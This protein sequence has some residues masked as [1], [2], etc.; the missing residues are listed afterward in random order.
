[1]PCSTVKPD[2]S[3]IGPQSFRWKGF[4]TIGM[5]LFQEIWSGNSFGPG[6]F[7]SL[8]GGAASP[9]CGAREDLHPEFHSSSSTRQNWTT[10][11]GIRKGHLAPKP[12]L[13]LLPG[14]GPSEKS[15]SGT[16]SVPNSHRTDQSQIQSLLNWIEIF[17]GTSVGFNWWGILRC[18]LWTFIL[19]NFSGT[20]PLGPYHGCSDVGAVS[21][22]W[23]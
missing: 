8:L 14:E 12:W 3:L 10:W 15:T 22:P 4:E 2:V 19:Q 7:W 11:A 20:S 16:V 5:K 21:N 6:E 9:E 1:M 23:R 13:W 18:L 17:P